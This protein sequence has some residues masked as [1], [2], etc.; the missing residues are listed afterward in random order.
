MSVS[1]RI[2]WAVAA[3]LGP[4]LAAA[5]AA[6]WL[7][8]VEAYKPALVQAVKE[9]TGR[10]L[11]I[12]GAM[13]LRM[14]PVPR[15]SA[16]RVHFA[17]A[18]GAEGAQ[19]VDVRW[20]GASPSWWAL[21]RG[22]VE[23]G[24]LTLYQ[25][26]IVLETDADGVPNWQF[27]P[28]AGASQPEGAPAEGFHLA[29]GELKVVEGTL[30]Y[31]NPQTHQTIK[32]ERVDATA[33]VRSLQGPLTISGNATVNGVPL[34]L[35]VSMSERKADGHD[36]SFSLQVLSGKLDFKGTISE[37]N[38]KGELKGHLGVTTGV[39]TDFIAAVVRA[40]GQASPK[41]DASVVGRFT[42][43]GGIELTPTRLAITDFKMA[44]GAET[45]SGTLAFEQGAAPSLKG[46]VALPKIDLEKWLA[47]LASPGAFQP[48]QPAGKTPA[49]PKPASLSPFPAALDVS[50]ALDVAEVVYRKGTVRDLAVAVEI[51]KGVIT[52]PQLKAVLPGDM[53]VEA[54]AQPN[55]ALSVTGPRMR[56]TLA[57]LDITPSGVPADKLQRLDLK[58]R[59]AATANGVQIADLVA[60]L[61]GQRATGSGGVTFATPLALSATLQAEAFDLDGYLPAAPAMAP[62]TPLTPLVGNAATPSAAGASVAIAT[63]I[64]AAPPPPDPATPLFALKAKVAKL[65]FRKQVAGGVEA[66]ASVQGNL[67]KVNT[68]KVADLLGAKA[69]VKG[70]V[71]D[72][73]T[74][75]RY[76]LTVNAT[77]PDADKVMAYAGLPKP[78]PDKIGAL[79][80]GGGVVGTSN[81]LSLRNVSATALGSTVRV[82]G[83][84]A[85]GGNIRFDFPTFNLQSQSAAGIGALAA[86]GALK[87]DSQR[88]AFDGS[89]TAFG[90]AMNGHVDATLGNRLNIN[91]NLRVPGTLDLDHWLG[92][93]TGPPAA[94]PT[95]APQAPRAT[96]GK[97]IDL[98]GFRAFDATVKLETSAVEVASLKI[99]YADLEATLRGGIATI[100]KLT[101]QFYGGAVDFSGTLDA[102]KNTL[103][104]DLKGSL[105]G[106]YFGEMLRGTAGTN[107]FGN[108]NLTVA[109][110]GKI[111][112]MDISVQGSGRTTEE[113]RDSLTGRGQVSGAL[114]PT[115]AKGSLGLASFA[116]GVGSIF[117]TEMGFGSA[118]LSAFVNHQSNIAGEVAIANGTV[119]LNNHTVQGQNAVAQ[120]TSRTNL[121]AA[122]TD[123]TIALDT[124]R[125]GPADYVVTVKGPVSS[126]TMTTRGGN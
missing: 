73:A 70:S 12:E 78:I 90:T 93:S 22:A 105:Q 99:A 102:A 43:D 5:V 92:V 30:S 62:S 60:D 121:A 63:L 10:E 33:R 46:R 83:A 122:T 119:S 117:S 18:T 115:V 35:E 114:Y 31:T 21:L 53:R 16:Q 23:I 27:K 95:P 67:L 14:L 96:T 71:T 124:G 91:V 25:P 125:R 41:F 44:M 81:A 40:G 55:G 123:T 108:D 29:I 15:V 52:V 6:P 109:V 3:L 68:F 116:T 69:D 24:Q 4:L 56:E 9:A 86:A 8:D 11:V 45:A 39:L 42:F 2:A 104:V 87:G 106:I 79:S 112:V 74:A 61:D 118:A 107:S 85:L 101:G 36:L 58:G 113:I 65:T 50:L 34:S 51:H 89:L 110:D 17:N 66:D 49:P 28:G 100:S 103:A 13:R 120:I 59:L 1:R 48:A 88:A 72:L 76:D 77:L 84:M 26:T 38:A 19:M 82:T 47:L 80:F 7:V 37:F 75:P 97:P 32:A 98:A 94:V 54:T 57:W 111:N 64:P 126:P 20:V